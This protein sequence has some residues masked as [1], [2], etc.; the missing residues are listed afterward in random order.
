MVTT[1]LT[2]ACSIISSTTETIPLGGGF[3]LN[4][5]TMAIVGGASIANKLLT[6]NA[7][8]AVSTIGLFWWRNQQN[9]GNGFTASFTLQAST[10]A[11]GY[12]FAF[13]LQ[14]NGPSSLGNGGTGLGYRGIGNYLA[15]RFERLSSAAYV[16]NSATA[17]FQIIIENSSGYVLASAN[18]WGRM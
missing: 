4:S 9:I 5:N 10:I 16:S 1:T 12:G 3:V 7:V 14:R 18:V 2:S 6:L 13:V 11:S 8:N 15:V 17:L